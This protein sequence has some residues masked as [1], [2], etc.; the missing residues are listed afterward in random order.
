[1]AVDERVGSGT[2]EIRTATPTDAAGMARLLEQLG[3]PSALERI[4]RR[5]LRLI[6]DDASQVFVAEAETWLVGLAALHITP[7]LELDQ[8]VGQLIALAVDDVRRR[9]GIGRALV[10]AVECEA[11]ARGCYAL[12][13][14][15]GGGRNDAHAFY[16]A[17][18]FEE[19]GRRFMKPLQ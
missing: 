8:P 1:M 16:R 18:G 4:E 19:T 12:I 13:L 15:S 9:Q 3:Y 5:L 2:V 6:A 14:N 17:L 10:E 11:H 7:L